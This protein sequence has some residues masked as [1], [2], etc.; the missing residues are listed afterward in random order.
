MVC[1]PCGVSG[2]TAERRHVGHVGPHKGVARGP[3]DRESPR[4]H[5]THSN[6]VQ[7][8]TKVLLWCYILLG[9]AQRRLAEQAK[10]TKDNAKVHNKH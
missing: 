5:T 10:N 8:I 6:R 3:R 4:T 1:C 7:R 2:P 9:H